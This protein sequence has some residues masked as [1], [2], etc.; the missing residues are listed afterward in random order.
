VLKATFVRIAG[1][2]DRIYVTRSDGSEVSWSFP[3]YGDGLPHDLVH[4][5]VES[6]C[7]LRAAFWGR[8]DAGADPAAITAKANRVGGK[9][10]YAAFGPD[11]AELYVAEALANA[12][13]FREGVTDDE[14]REA[15][16]AECRQL[17]VLPPELSAIE[18]E[19]I[20]STLRDL[21]RR[22]QSLLPKGSLSVTFPPLPRS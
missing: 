14:I 16:A 21:A 3:S 8:V 19:R 12:G 2:R 9:D 7:G 11:Q 22:W 1:E 13:W 10:K 20:R 15:V 17:E 4:W 5:V 6:C 18:T